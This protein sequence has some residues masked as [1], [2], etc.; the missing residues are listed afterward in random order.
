MNWYKKANHK[1]IASVTFWVEGTDKISQPMNKLDICNNLYRFIYN[2]GLSEQLGL[3]FDAVD[4]D[5][6][7]GNVFG[8]DGPISIYLGNPNVRGETIQNII[9]KYN[10]DMAGMIKL[11]FLEIN[12]SGARRDTNV[13]RILIEENNTTNF[14][15]IPEM[16][17][18]NANARALLEL[19]SNEGMEGLSGDDEGIGGTLNVAELKNTIN[20]IEQNNYV[21]NTYTQEPTMEKEEGKPTMYDGGRSYE[22]LSRYI[23][24]LK[25]IIN[26]IEKNNLPL[27]QINFG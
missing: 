7:S 22:Q 9:N 17:V 24:G 16:N 5:A 1:K 20:N 13:A 10:E 12:K 21:L 2:N 23:N 27:M 6:S 18:S 14:E 26:Y 11:R 15:E 8:P 4:P 19:L 25:E 3:G